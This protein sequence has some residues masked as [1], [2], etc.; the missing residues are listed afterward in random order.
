MI[1]WPVITRELRVASRSPAL[2][3]LRLAV[4]LIGIA[5]LWFTLLRLGSGLNSGRTIFNAVHQ[6]TALI[7]L[8]LT[9]LMTADTISKEKREGT[10]DLLFLTSLTS[11]KFVSTKFVSQFV[12]VLCVWA[13]MIP[14]S[15]VPLLSGGVL[16]S[17][18]QTMFI[19]EL[20]VILLGLTAGLLASALSKRM[21]GALV[22]AISFSATFLWL[23][24]QFMRSSFK[25]NLNLSQAS[26]F[27]MFALNLLVVGFAAILI[28]GW[29][30]WMI[31]RTK[32]EQSEPVAQR[33]FRN[34]FLTPRYWRGTFQRTMQRRMDSN[35]LIW[36][37]YRTA[38]SRVGRTA[39]I[40][41][42]IFMESMVIASPYGME[43]LPRLHAIFAL[44][45]LVFMAITSAT[46]FQR[47]K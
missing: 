6:V 16:A 27:Q 24:V 44:A 20:T 47:E 41:A 8:V 35:P 14:L 19:V 2:Y 21:L 22:L 30:A 26:M 40:G 25:S 37:E 29:I 18:V 10:L 1:S 3:R 13:V 45:F 7:L 32:Q 31:K 15:T 39:M 36:L 4:G 28:L 9:P 42:L 23:D 43:E 11:L 46:S 38:W 17:D 33:W 5:V 12:R 34:V